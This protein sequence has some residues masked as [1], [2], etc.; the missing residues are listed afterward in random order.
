MECED[1]QE[2]QGS[3]EPSTESKVSINDNDKLKIVFFPCWDNI[4]PVSLLTLY[5]ANTVKATM[6]KDNMIWP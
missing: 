1:D 6:V 4:A 3:T 5:Y 2:E